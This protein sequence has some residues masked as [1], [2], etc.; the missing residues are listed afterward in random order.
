MELET[1]VPGEP[2]FDVL[3]F[4]SR[5]NLCV[6][7]HARFFQDPFAIEWID[8]RNDYGE[9]RINFLGMSDASLLDVTFAAAAG[10]L[11][12]RFPTFAR[13]I[14][15]HNA[16]TQAVP[17][18]HPPLARSMWWKQPTFVPPFQHIKRP[19]R[20]PGRPA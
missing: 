9:E 8:E 15:R 18:T 20:P 10:I 7:Y 17:R 12:F 3:C 1:L 2:V 16:S 19:R 14:A 13:R 11:R 4:V 5:G 6:R